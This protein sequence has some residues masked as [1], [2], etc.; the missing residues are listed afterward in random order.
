MSPDEC[1][2]AARRLLTIDVSEARAR[3]AE[4]TAELGAMAANDLERANAYVEAVEEDREHE[5]ELHT[6]LAVLNSVIGAATA[7]GPS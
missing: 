4:I 1:A 5:H 3:V 2:A 6:E 7:G